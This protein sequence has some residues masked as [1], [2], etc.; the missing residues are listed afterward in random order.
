MRDNKK[1]TYGSCEDFVPLGVILLDQRKK[2]ERNWKMKKRIKRILAILCCIAMT[3][4]IMGCQKEGTNDEEQKE[5]TDNEEQ[6]ENAD[7]ED[8]TNEIDTLTSYFDFGSNG[9]EEYTWFENYL[10]E[11]FGIYLE[12]RIQGFDSS[13]LNLMLSD[14]ELTDLI[15]MQ[16]KS[17]VNIAVEGNMLIDFDDY[18]D[19]LPNIY[20]ED[21][22][23]ALQYMRDSFGGVYML[24]LEVGSQ[25]GIN[26]S[27]QLR[28][29]L[30]KELGMPEMADFYELLDVMAD[31][32]ELEPETAD[33][34]P[35]YGMGGWNDWDGNVF[36][37]F[38]KNYFVATQGYTIGDVS[39]LVEQKID[40]TG[41]LRSI[42]DD[43]S[44]YYEGLKWAYTANQMGVLDPESATMN[45]E[46]FGSKVSSGQYFGVMF[47]WYAPFDE[48][49]DDWKAYEAI[50]PESAEIYEY[51]DYPVGSGTRFIGISSKCEH[52]DKALAFL[53]W[54]YS[55]EGISLF[56]NGE[57]GIY[58]DEDEN[59]NI[60]L[61]DYYYETKYIGE[62][63]EHPEGGSYDIFGIINTTPK[64]NSAVDENDEYIQYTRRPS[65]RVKHVRSLADSD[66]IE[67]YNEGY[68]NRYERA[69]AEGNNLIGYTP[70]F[71][72]VEPVS[73][74]IESIRGEIGSL[75][76]TTSWKM[77]YAADEAE[78]EALWDQLQEDAETL[79]IQTVLE[80]AEVR[81]ENA[82][83]TAAK[84]GISVE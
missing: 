80:D 77:I 19:Q 32:K 64:M 21:Y 9:A 23:E 22:A 84:Y 6:K 42:L 13:I 65:A 69:R 3:A 70:A 55:D 4:S 12:S 51:A 10:G 67:N 26:N 68:E 56:L 38:V 25:T 5:N 14:G 79:G 53:D 50:W 74:D 16:N 31:M 52:I 57:K 78:F 36:N 61:T 27:P 60:Y 54:F 33:G 71:S 37:C 47:D 58:W 72:F 59:G 63:E 15:G 83:V 29:D 81:W 41:E 44:M 43:G 75:V 18:K 48:D 20:S 30:Y 73:T 2:K 34:L 62:A 7:D 17:D 46:T 39:S 66:Y 45:F 76:V 1:H 8:K 24:P 28:Y 11:K 40:G 82:K 49:A 35:T